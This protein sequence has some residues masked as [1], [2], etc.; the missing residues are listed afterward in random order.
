MPTDTPEPTGTATPA[1]SDTPIPTATANDTPTPTATTTW[2][3]APTATATPTSAT[4]TIWT[5]TATPGI[6]LSLRPSFVRMPV[7]EISRIEIVLELGAQKADGLQA[8]LDFEPSLLAIVDAAGNPVTQITPEEGFSHIFGNHVDA[9]AGTIDYVVGANVPA[10]GQAIVASFYVKGLAPTAGAFVRFHRAFP[11]WT[12]AS[13]Q[14]DPLPIGHYQEALFVLFG[15]PTPSPTR[16][17][18]YFPLVFKNRRP[19]A[20]L[21]FPLVTHFT[22]PPAMLRF[23]LI[24]QSGR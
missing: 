23:P 1:P 19:S 5:P 15:P 22:R 21:Y 8:Y 20:P 13:I 14:N 16:P 12:M 10:S 2:T 7:G 17:T 6:A 24:I 4:P 3:P 9:Q 11:R 18:H